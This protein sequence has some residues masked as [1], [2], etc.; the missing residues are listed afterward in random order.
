MRQ[1]AIDCSE[2][3]R[4]AQRIMERRQAELPRPVK[5]AMRVW[6]IPQVPGKDGNAF[7]VPVTSL[8]QAKLLLRV[9]ADYDFYQLA[10]RIKGDFSNA[11]G[12]EAFDGQEW[13]DWED[14]ETGNQ[15][16]DFEVDTAGLL[17]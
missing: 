12:L 5:G 2:A 1:K 15:I 13:S 16:D 10:N 14:P 17:V 6:W 9:L 3:I 4:T 11:G 7:Y 8:I